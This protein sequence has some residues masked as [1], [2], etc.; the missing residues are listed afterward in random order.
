MGLLCSGEISDCVFLELCEKGFAVNPTKMREFSILSYHRFKDDIIVLAHGDFDSR[1]RWGANFTRLARFYRLEYEVHATTVSYLDLTL[2]IAPQGHIEFEHFVKPSSVW[3]PL[4]PSS[5]HPRSVH[6]AWPRSNLLRIKKHCRNEAAADLHVRA[7]TTRMRAD[8]G[9]EPNSQNCGFR[10]KQPPC[11]HLAFPYHPIWDV[12]R[13]AP[14]IRRASEAFRGRSTILPV[15]VC[16]ELGAPHL[17]S[18]HEGV[19]SRPRVGF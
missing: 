5:A 2:S 14:A 12:V 7:F 10:P 17:F 8:L 11:S 18:S 16:W 6:L 19:Q 4:S 9:V 3:S 15:Q 13:L 1:L